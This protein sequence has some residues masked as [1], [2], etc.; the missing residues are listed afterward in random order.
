MKKLSIFLLFFP[1]ALF[2]QVGINTTSP[3]EASVLDVRSTLDGVRVG[4][5]LPPKVNLAQRALIPVTSADDGLIVFLSEGSTRC[6]Q[7][8]NGTENS[9]ENMHCLA[10]APTILGIQ[11][12]EP[13]PATPTLNF[14]DNFASGSFQTGNGTNPSTPT[15]LNTRSYGVISDIADID[16]GPINASAFSEVSVTFRLAAFSI[17]TAGNGVDGGDTVGV[18]ISDD[19]GVT[20]SFEL[21]IAG[22]SNAR[23]DY[24]ATGVQTIAYDGDNTPVQVTTPTGLIGLSTITVNNLPN[25]ANLVVGIV[26]ENNVAN[27]L[28]VIDDVVVSGN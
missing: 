27:E 2:S 14:T 5:F 11:D 8:Y 18:Y 4:G 9:W 15:F 25:V 28:W 3:S 22:N 20:F 19:G 12:F 26:L 13:A 6:L 17:N 23:Y 24:S 16:F 21:E 1:V 7:I 10:L